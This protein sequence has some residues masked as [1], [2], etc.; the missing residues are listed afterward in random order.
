MN[1]WEKKNPQGAISDYLKT[2]PD[3]TMKLIKH[4]DD[5]ESILIGIQQLHKI[6]LQP[7]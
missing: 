1:K 6:S 7:L 4:K 2:I 3:S 5:K